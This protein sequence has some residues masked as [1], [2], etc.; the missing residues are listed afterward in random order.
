M[1]A[2]AQ[3]LSPEQVERGGDAMISIVEK[4]TERHQ[5]E[6]ARTGLVALAPMLNPN[7]TTRWGNAL[8]T[9]L[10]NTDDSH[11]LETASGGLIEFA[12]KLSPEQITRSW[13]ALIAVLKKAPNS[14]GMKTAEK[15]L[16]ALAPRL[17][18]E[19]A[20]LG[21]DSLI[22]VMEKATDSNALISAGRSL[23]T[24]VPRL[25]QE[26]ITRC[27]DALIA[28]ME[29]TTELYDLQAVGDIFTAIAPQLSPDDRLRIAELFVAF[30][31]TGHNERV[32]SQLLELLP[33]LEHSTHDRMSMEILT[34][35]LDYLAMSETYFITEAIDLDSFRPAIMVMINPRSIARLMQHPACIGE[36]REWMLQR[37]EE[38]IFHNG[39]RVF[40]Q[41]PESETIIGARTVLT[42]GN[43]ATP[44]TANGDLKPNRSPAEP[45]PRRSHTLHDAATWIQHNWPDFDLEATH[46]V[47]WRGEPE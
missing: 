45:P 36:P 35:L 8:I 31:P 3:K 41:L 4:A 26:Q 7:Q 27:G 34:T 15:C 21:A 46:P 39:Q 18:D 29:R 23:V 20:T 2:L 37:F 47:T 33:Q 30:L 40:L 38:L 42:S 12:P 24:M 25:N 6:S 22:A 5:L 32:T 28:V 10:E 19:Q 16:V 43:A 9:L 44:E 14:D 1:V 13:K 17:S 11:I